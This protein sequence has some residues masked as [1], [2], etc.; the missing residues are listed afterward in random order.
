MPEDRS[1]P[2]ITSVDQYLTNYLSNWYLERTIRVPL[3]FFGSKEIAVRF[4]P[5]RDSIDSISAKVCS[6]EVLKHLYLFFTCSKIFLLII[7]VLKSIVCTTISCRKECKRSMW[8]FRLNLSCKFSAKLDKQQDSQLPFA[9]QRHSL[10]HQFPSSARF[11]SRVSCPDLH[12]ISANVCVEF[13]HGGE[14]LHGLRGSGVSI[15][16]AGAR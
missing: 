8:S 1:I 11:A 13:A 5:D 12:D 7:F 4:R 3:T 9:T 6:E 15:L 16:A 14:L 10:R 2:C